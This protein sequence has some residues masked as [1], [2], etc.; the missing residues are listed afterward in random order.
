MFRKSNKIIG[1]I[2]VFVM[3]FSLTTPVAFAKASVP[4]ALTLQQ[5]Y[6][7]A[8]G[9][10][11]ADNAL[12]NVAYPYLGWRTNGGPW[13]NACED[14]LASQ[15]KNMK[16]TEGKATDGDKYWIQKDITEPGGAS[17]GT[18]WAPQYASLELLGSE[19]LTKAGQSFNVV[20][21]TFD[22]NSRYYPTEITQDWVVANIGSAKESAMNVRCHLAGNSGFTSP[23]NT[24]LIVASEAAI[25][26]EVVDVGVVKKL[27]NPTKYTW[28][29]NTGTGASLNGKIIFADG[30]N[31]RSNVYALAKQEG[32]KVSLCSQINDYNHP[33]IN[34]KELY[35]DNVQYASIKNTS[36]TGAL[37]FNLSPQ[38]ERYLRALLA[39]AKAKRTP[40]MMKAE[41]IGTMYPYSAENPLKTVVAEIKGS[42]KADE[43][44]VFM[45]HLQEPGANDNATGVGMQ[46]EMVRTLKK[47]IDEG[48]LPRPD[49]TLTF[50]WGA[51][52]IMGTLWGGQ[53]PN[54]M[55]NVKAALAL[56]MVGEDPKKT[57][58]IMRIE[59]MPD[60]SAYYNYG[61]DT[62]PGQAPAASDQFVR[63]P[64]TH[65]LWGAGDP[66]AEKPNPYPGH[67]LNDLY[68][69]SAS[70]V[71]KDSP[72]FQVGSNPWE[73]GSDHDTFLWNADPLP[74]LLTWHFTDYVYHTSM[75]TMDKV[76]KDELRNVGLTT[77]NVGYM[78]AN[79]GEQEATEIMADVKAQAQVRFDEE[80]NNSAG[81]LRW[82]YDQDIAANKTNDLI[83]ADMT[84]GLAEEKKILNAWGTWYEEAIKSAR[85]L[86]DIPVSAAYAQSEAS[87]VN[88]IH[89]LLADSITNAIDQAPVFSDTFRHWAA[90]SIKFVTARKLFAGVGNNKFAPDISMTRGMLVTVLGRANGIDAATYDKKPVFTDVSQT[91]YYAPYILW[92]SKNGLVSGMG[93]GKFGPDK[94]I[95]RSEMAVI[96]ANYMK[97]VNKSAVGTG[98]TELN[99]ADATDIA[100]WA[101]ESVKLVTTAG[102]ITGTT[103]NRFDSNGL[104]TRAQVATVMKRLIEKTVQ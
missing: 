62:L 16:F 21:S 23:A 15:L 67:F 73:G 46:L 20:A 38:D 47:L 57:G 52:T 53:N 84:T 10:L 61:L 55:K 65:T 58:G 6:D 98:T 78:I 34:G 32:A 45:G 54:E 100:D 18:I 44:V 85:G 8:K 101:I 7:V 37:A 14:W 5:I 104:S 17:L 50:I 63:L 94:A 93:N 66:T 74:A 88:A 91:A 36:T 2:T 68:F 103:G 3:L 35:A 1:L 96:I 90:S 69:T 86:C 56:D 24:E 83:F 76:S 64:D 80:K 12:K 82:I 89:A 75:D 9:E 79:A 49:R 25:V 29:N 59:K 31:T 72:G 81:H 33:I 97:F 77:I 22:P 4:D 102:L 70:L 30:E 27:S 39:D 43:R 95:T 19:G 71:A 26:A 99:Y 87:N 28:T 42:S 92:A 41:A 48:T 60:P 11:S 13:F 51:E 40:V